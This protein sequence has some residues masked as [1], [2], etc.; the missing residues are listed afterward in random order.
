MPAP[1]SRARSPSRADHGPHPEYRTEWWYYTG[2]LAGADGTPYG[3]QLTFFRNSLAPEM[4]ERASTLATNQVYMA[5]FA[6]T[7]GG[8]GEHI[9]LRPLQPR[10]RGTC[11]RH[12]GPRLRGSGSKTGPPQKSRRVSCACRR[13]HQTPDG[14]VE[15]DLTLRETRPPVLHGEQG[16]HQK[17]PE[18]GNASYYYSLVGLETAGVITA[19]GAPVAV[20]GVSWMDHEFGT[21]ALSGNAVGWDWFSIQ[22]DDGTALMLYEIRTA[23][24]D[25]LPYVEGTLVWPDGRQE[26]LTEDDFTVTPT[27]EWTS[28]ATGITY[29]AGWEIALP[30]QESQLTVTPL[31]ADQE[32]DVSFVYWEGAVDVA[33]S[34]QGAP[35]HGRGLCRADR[36][37]GAESGISALG[38]HQARAV[39][40]PTPL[41]RR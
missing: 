12:R 14:P 19:T 32:M 10:R 13:P 30:G 41:F 26:K 3:Y 24:G 20:T 6:L 38:P 31:V 15:I 18:P 7:D 27:G 17:G 34:V 5:H 16:L 21:S 2:N 22:L 23:E 33:G 25:V 39:R 36:V 1:S 28:P 40:P 8:R 9:E 11:G 4:Q 37:R 35:V 29:P